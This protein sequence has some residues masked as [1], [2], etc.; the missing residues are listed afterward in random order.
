MHVEK[1]PKNSIKTNRLLNKNSDLQKSSSDSLK[2][3]KS[4]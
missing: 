1:R 4:Y 3:D 2:T